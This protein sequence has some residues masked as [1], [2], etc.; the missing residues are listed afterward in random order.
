MLEIQKNLIA[1]D[2][3][4]MVVISIYPFRFVVI[5]FYMINFKQNI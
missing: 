2:L 1:T 3:F 5:V 4:K